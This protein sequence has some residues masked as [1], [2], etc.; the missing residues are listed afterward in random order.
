MMQYKLVC[1]DFDHTLTVGVSAA[2]HVATFLDCIDDMAAAEREFREGRLTTQGFTNRFAGNF[3]GHDQDAI[4]DH[5]LDIPLISDISNTVQWLKSL[6]LRVVI[7][8][9][10][11]RD[12]IAPVGTSLGFDAVSGAGLSSAGGKYDGGVTAY[13]PLEAKITF[14]QQQ[15]KI[16]DCDLSQAIAVG[17]G[18]SDLPLFHSVGYS[19]AFNAPSDVN[20]QSAAAASGHSCSAIRRVIEPL[21]T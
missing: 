1:F 17:D 6:G 8:T 10:G 18:L 3:Q 19:V 7:N 16:A 2:E 5:M 15:A 21:L 13:F 9:V 4:A 14:A 11:F 20:A 12:I